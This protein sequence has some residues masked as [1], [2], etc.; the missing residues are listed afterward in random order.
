MTTLTGRTAN[1]P[2]AAAL[3]PAV[4]VFLWSTGFIGGKLGLPYAEPMTF[5]SIRFAIVAAC[6]AALALLVGAPWP[7]GRQIAHVAVAGLLLHGVY[8]GGVFASIHA[9]VE[10]GTSALIVGVQPI[11]TAILAGPVLGEKVTLRQWAGLLLG[12]AG[13][14]LVV[15]HKLEQGLGSP[16]GMALSVMALVGITA[17]TLYQKRF[18]A[19][20]DLRAGNAVQFLAAFLLTGA[21]ALALESRVVDWSGEFV[22]ALGWLVIVLSFGAITLLMLLIRQGAASRVASLFFLV[23]PMTALIA[24][25]LFGERFG[26]LAIAGMVL[27]AVGVALVNLPL[28]RP[29]R[30]ERP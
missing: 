17:G 1:R 4:F 20:M 11:L 10:A 22:F 5:L 23:P 8:L 27:V 6:L 29:A 24:W 13:I 28:P 19:A 30:S 12:L 14:V 3:M 7:R 15:E 25:F 16:A 26:P 18:C 2:N 9:G 21:L